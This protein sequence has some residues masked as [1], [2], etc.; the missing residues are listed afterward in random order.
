MMDV[1]T[2]KKRSEIMSKIRS[3]NTKVERLV[4]CELRKRGVY[5]QK[6][7]KKAKGK[8][9]IALPRKKKAVFIDGD[10]WHGRNLLKQRKRLPK[11]YWLPKIEKNVKNDRRNGLL[12]KRAGWKILRVWEKEIIKNPEKEIEKISNFLLENK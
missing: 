11:K 12:L 2:R 5:F 8:P 10:F 7:Y 1:F 4:F 9:D 3:E 6:H